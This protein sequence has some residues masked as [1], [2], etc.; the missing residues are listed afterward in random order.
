M[1]QGTAPT[2]VEARE[3]AKQD[4]QDD[5][6]KALVVSRSALASCRRLATKMHMRHHPIAGQPSASSNHPCF[7]SRR[8]PKH[9]SQSRRLGQLTRF[10]RSPL[11]PRGTPVGDDPRLA[12][13]A[14]QGLRQASIWRRVLRP[15]NRD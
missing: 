3:A 15:L 14:E 13:A 12:E 6:I 4:K 10:P 9:T 8:S 2:A 1:M 11:S 5:I 7:A